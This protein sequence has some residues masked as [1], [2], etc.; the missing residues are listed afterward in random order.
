MSAMQNSSIKLLWD[1]TIQ[2][3]RHLSHNHPDIVFVDFIKNHC[4]LINVA[5]P[6]DSHLSNKVTEKLERYTDLKLEIQKMWSMRVS[7]V[8]VVIAPL[9]SIPTCLKKN[10]QLISIYYPSLIPKLQK[11][12]LLSSCHML[13]HF[14]TKH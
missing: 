4:L 2:T 5:I 10:L 12:V 1:F 6:G 11:N 14:V 8:P 13:R 3:D 7:V 9:G